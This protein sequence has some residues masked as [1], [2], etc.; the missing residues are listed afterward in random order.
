MAAEKPAAPPITLTS[1]DGIEKMSANERIK[2]ESQGLFYVSAKGEVHTFLDE[3]RALDSGEADTLSGGAKELSKFFGVY[4]QQARGDRGKK[5]KDFF[6]MVRITA[7]GGGGFSAKQWVALDDAAERLSGGTIRL[8]SRQSI[9][10]HH[11]YGPQLASLV[12]HLNRE[13]RDHGTLSSCGDVNRNVMGSPI[14]GLDPEYEVGS[15]ELTE[16]IA[17]ELAPKTSAYFQIFL[18]EDDGRN[19]RPINPEEP[20]YGAQYLPRKFKIGFAHPTDNSVDVL[21]QDVG[22]VPAE[23]DGSV[24]DL[25]TGGGLGITHNMPKTAALPALYF[26]RIRRDQVVDA[27]RAIVTLQK[28]NGDRKDR[29]QARWKYTLR[30]L[31]V[32]RV[33]RELRERF[34]IALEEAEPRPLPP[35]DLHLGWH[36]QRGGNGYYGISIENGRIDAATRK[37]IRAAV[38]AFDL[39]VRLTPQQDL[40]LCNVPDREALERLLAEHGVRDPSSVSILRANSMACPAKPTCGLAMTEAERILPTY[41]DELEAAGLGDVDVVIRMTG[42]PNGC[43]RPP[44]AEIGI[45]GY[46]K[47]DHVILVGGSREG[48]RIAQELYPRVPGEQMIPVLTG[49]LTAI[50]DRN[51][52]GLPAGEFLQRSDPGELRSWVGIDD[53]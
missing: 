34:E 44:T 48:S 39:E 47:N 43:A 50:R 3:V 28:A 4:K 7:P 45:F 2:V 41:V 36:D 21:T 38:E 17:K 15:R 52:E 10:Y 5:L 35:M 53:V 27:V 29:R 12:R 30:R 23:P 46:G 18:S 40:L 14:D 8:T 6:F 31:G 22:L 13:Y 20:L 51:P 32:E 9:Q 37:G 33:K 26:G 24:W 11:V 25:Y 16:V 49:L 19:T 42:C 1:G